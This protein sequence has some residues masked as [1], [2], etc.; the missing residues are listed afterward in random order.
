MLPSWSG[1]ER[2]GVN[3][4]DLTLSTRRHHNH[5]SPPPGVIT[6][7]RRECAPGRSG[8]ARRQP[9]PRPPHCR[10]PRTPL[11]THPDAPSALNPQLSLCWHPHY[12]AIETPARVRGGVQ[13]ND[14]R[15]EMAC[16][17]TSPQRKATGRALR[18]GGACRQQLLS[19][20]AVDERE[21]LGRDG[22]LTRNQRDDTSVD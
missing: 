13:Q 21:H 11:C 22:E 7:S 19:S 3:R 10:R 6:A 1:V 18:G 16:M 12:G 14:R 20:S 2:T 17:Q 8:G 5:S 4:H 9:T 15:K